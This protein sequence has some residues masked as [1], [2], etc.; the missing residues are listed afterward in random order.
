MAVGVAE[1]AEAGRGTSG[2]GRTPGI[3]RWG[4]L[5]PTGIGRIALLTQQIQVQAGPEPKALRP[6]PR[7]PFWECRGWESGRL[8]E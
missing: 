2:L 4:K 6:Q 1:W 5:R 3:I 7:A 8:G